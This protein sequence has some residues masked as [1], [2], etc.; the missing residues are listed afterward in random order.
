MGS[1]TKQES[2]KI[3]G[4]T[5]KLAI[6][7]IQ[8]LKKFGVQKLEGNRVPKKLQ[9]EQIWGE[10]TSDAFKLTFS[11]DA[12]LLDYPQKHKISDMSLQG[13]TSIRFNRISKLRSKTLRKFSWDN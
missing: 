4:P 12:T 7:K 11:I 10:R 6:K 9:F 3:W 5:K 1:E 13:I 8:S 2:K